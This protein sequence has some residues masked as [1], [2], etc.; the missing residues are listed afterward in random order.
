VTLVHGDRLSQ[1]ASDV[2]ARVTEAVF[3]EFRST[4]PVTE[5][6]AR[7]RRRID[8]ILIDEGQK[9]MRYAQVAKR[10]EEARVRFNQLTA[11]TAIDVEAQEKK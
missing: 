6:P 2:A 10:A 7:I 9:L 11:G 5:L 3:E 8:F 1:W 4:A